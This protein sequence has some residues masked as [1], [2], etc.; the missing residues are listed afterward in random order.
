MTTDD[1]EDD[2]DDSGDAGGGR[3]LKQMS[4]NN[5]VIA[6]PPPAMMTPKT[7]GKTRSFAANGVNNNNHSGSMTATTSTTT[8]AAVAPTP[9]PQR[10]NGRRSSFK[11]SMTRGSLS[12]GDERTKSME[13]SDIEMESTNAL[14]P[15]AHRS[16]LGEFLSFDSGF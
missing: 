14:D 11:R 3:I 13:C 4:N 8:T 7:R 6:A 2:D 10:R 12:S 5:N 16:K 1:D 9:N 15:A